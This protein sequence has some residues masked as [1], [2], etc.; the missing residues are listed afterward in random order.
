[1]RRARKERLLKRAVQREKMEDGCSFTKPV[2]E[3]QVAER[4]QARPR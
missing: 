1:M 4:E 2:I 3:R